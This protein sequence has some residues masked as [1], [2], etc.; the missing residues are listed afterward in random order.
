[1]SADLVRMTSVTM[2]TGPFTLTALPGFDVFAD[3]VGVPIH[4]GLQ[5]LDAQG[6]PVPQR[7]VG[8]G[9]LLV[10][11][12]L[13][14]DSVTT[15]SNGA[16]PV[17]FACDSIVV[18]DVMSKAAIE[19][20]VAASTR[21]GLKTHNA[22]AFDIS[23]ADPVQQLCDA[24]GAVTI[25]GLTGL[26]AGAPV[27]LT[28]RNTTSSDIPVTFVPSI[29]GW[30]NGAEP[31]IVPAFGEAKIE[32]TSTGVI[33]ADVVGTWTAPPSSVR[34]GIRVRQRGYGAP[35]HTQTQN[36]AGALVMG[37]AGRLSL[38]PFL[39][40]FDCTLTSIHIFNSTSSPTAVAHA[41]LYTGS[42]A[43][44]VTDDFTTEPLQVDALLYDSGPQAMSAGGAK[45]Q[46]ISIPVK[47]GQIIW[48]GIW[49][50]E[51]IS[52]FSFSLNSP[53]TASFRGDTNNLI[54]SRWISD[55]YAS[56]PAT[57]VVVSQTTDGTANSST[58]CLASL[59]WTQP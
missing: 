18:V 5:G 30:A 34:T 13:Q 12:T 21:A 20:I 45:S 47:K 22:N 36:A 37:A 33:V 40:D 51:N 24:T 8:I 14:I 28:I 32:L 2:G 19:G 38:V 39:V 44:G 52:F 7:L 17:V 48:L 46:T 15:G 26:V 55:A 35:A 56:P 10:D 3:A 59:R 49:C 43:P 50:N 16:S 42:E 54:V 31:R 41:L 6:A 57:G 27:K 53:V 58:R 25:T 1:M 29:S 11:G 9:Q 4:V 23:F